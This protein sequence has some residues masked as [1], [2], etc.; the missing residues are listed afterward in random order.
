MD[1]FG[2][3]FLTIYEAK[4]TDYKQDANGQKWRRMGNSCWFTN[5]DL[6]KR[7]IPLDLYAKYK[8]E[9]YPTYDDYE[10]IECGICKEIPED[11]FGIIGVPITYLP[12]HCPEQFKILKIVTPKINN[13]S[14]YK[15]LLIMRKV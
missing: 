3:K 5:F 1:I 8:S 9:K 6:P 13:K 12:Y 11:F 4:E 14:K 7:H 10:A 2:L 15:R